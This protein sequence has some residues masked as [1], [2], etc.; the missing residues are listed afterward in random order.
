[1][2]ALLDHELD[3]RGISKTA[4]KTTDGPEEPVNVTTK[5]A[6]LKVRELSR[7]KGTHG[8]VDSKD[9]FQ[10]LSCSAMVFFYMDQQRASSS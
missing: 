7:C 10:P 4:R 2:V 5:A 1:M 8:E 6:R 3:H 9:A